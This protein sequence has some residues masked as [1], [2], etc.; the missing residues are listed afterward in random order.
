MRNL[1]LFIIYLWVPV[2]LSSQKVRF[3]DYHCV[4]NQELLTQ[5]V[6]ENKQALQNGLSFPRE[7]VFVPVKLHLVADS[8][9]LGRVD[10]EDVLD[11][12]CDLNSEFAGSGF[13]FYIDDGFNFVDN[14]FVYTS[15]TLGAGVAE[16]T[17][18]RRDVGE[19]SLNIF[20][21]QT[22]MS[23]STENGTV[24]GFYAIGN[25]W[26]VVRQ[27]QIGNG[28]NTLAHEVGHYFSLMHPHSGW[29]PSP[30]EEALHGNPVLI[31]TI[32]GVRVEL[33]DGSNCSVSGDRICD[34]PPDYNFGFSWNTRCSPFNLNVMDRN[35]DTIV[36]QQNNYM[37]YFLGCAPYVFSDGQKDVMMAEYMSARR[38][39]IRTG[40][41]PQTDEIPN[42]LELISPDNNT[43]TEFFNG[44]ELRWTEVENASQYLLKIRSGSIEIN[45]ITDASAVF[46]T[47]LLPNRTYTWSVTPFNEGY[48][49]AGRQTNI[50]RTNDATTSTID[51]DFIESVQ[52]LPNPV[53][54]GE[55]MK[56]EITSNESAQASLDIY[57][58]SGKRVHSQA[59]SILVGKNNINLP[60]NQLQSGVYMLSLATSKGN[61]KRKLIISTY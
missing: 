4:E 42:T 22:A 18:Q 7:D 1:F 30:W 2:L 36:P 39:S 3:A 46:I 28:E 32:N 34:T 5:R 10:L 20:I 24:L 40:F 11:Q 12:M 61:I 31:T 57:S 51:P 37:S 53:N 60:T 58:L 56:I 52:V 29:E 27:N 47:D 17:R 6:I 41:I 43:T 21:T 33:A 55:E 25:D 15:P 59:T 35:M 50:L 38:S 44:V 16:M 8:D 9:G 13:H 23:G 45:R 49:C 26:V 14:D 54:Q 19:E 48:T